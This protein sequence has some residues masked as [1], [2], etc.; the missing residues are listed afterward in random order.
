MRNSRATTLQRAGRL[1]EGGWHNLRRQVQVLAQELN[2]LVSQEPAAAYAC[3]HQQWYHNECQYLIRHKMLSIR[4]MCG[5]RQAGQRLRHPDFIP[6]QGAGQE[7]PVGHV[8][9]QPVHVVVSYA[10][11]RHAKEMGIS[12]D[13]HCCPRGLGRK[14]R[15]TPCG[16][17]RHCYDQDVHQCPLDKH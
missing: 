4:C 12:S 11:H 10:M 5:C 16:Q 14:G 1:L 3:T 8:S 2:A 6:S 7:A 15:R 13:F 17:Y 9:S